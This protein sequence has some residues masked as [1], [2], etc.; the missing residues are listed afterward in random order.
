M[1]STG[2]TAALQPEDIV[3]ASE[4]ELITLM[5]STTTH[6]PRWRIND[7]EYK[8]TLLPPGFTADGLNLEYIFETSRVNISCFFRVIAGGSVVDICSPNTIVVPGDVR[9]ES[10]GS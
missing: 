6:F 3:T 2:Y 5:C 9:G 8:V 7:N 1:E 10:F 4:G